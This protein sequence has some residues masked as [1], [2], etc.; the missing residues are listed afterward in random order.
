M[1]DTN[2][3]PSR[4][5][6]LGLHGRQTASGGLIVAGRTHEVLSAP[7][8][9]M[10]AGA[11]VTLVTHG[12][13]YT[14][15]DADAERLPC[16]ID[17]WHT[18]N[19]GTRNERVTA[20]PLGLRDSTECRTTLDA[21]AAAGIWKTGQVYLCVSADRKSKAGRRRLYDLFANDPRVTKKGGGAAGAVPFREYCA[22]IAAHKYVLSPPGAGPDCHRH[23]EALALGAIPVVERSVA[24]SQFEALPILFVDRWEDATPD[25]LDAMAAERGLWQRFDGRL[26]DALRFDYW[27]RMILGS[28]E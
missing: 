8:V 20:L 7:C 5:L 28:A 25:M 14:V 26:R 15:T 11:P 4:N 22:D 2:K 9:T 6:F 16:G 27:E 17:R 18:V 10:S 1:S 3:P 21:V 19:C 12:S 24:M 23:W 13:D